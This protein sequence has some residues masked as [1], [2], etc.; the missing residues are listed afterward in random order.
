MLVPLQLIKFLLPLNILNMPYKILIVILLT[1]ITYIVKAQDK[2]GPKIKFGKITTEELSKNSYEIDTAAEAV[3]LYD[4]CNVQ[5]EG[6]QK[7]DFNVLYS[8]HMRI[9]ILNKNAFDLATVSIPLSKYSQMEEKVKKLEAITYNLEN[10]NIVESKLD[11]S[12]I[13]KDKVEKNFEI[14][15]FTLPNVKEGSVIEYVYTVISPYSRSLKKWAFQGRNPTLWSELNISIP[16]IYDFLT[17][18]YGTH[19]YS[20][21]KTTIGQSHYN[22]TIPSDHAAISNDH[23]NLRLNTY[24][25]NWAMQNLPAIKLEN[26][27]TNIKN[28]IAAIEFQLSTVRYPDQTPIPVIKPWTTACEQ[29]LKHEDFGAELYQ[30]NNWLKDELAKMSLPE[31]PV[32]KAKKIFV[33]V[34]DNF[35]CNDNSSLFL[36]S[37]LKKIYQT[38]AGNVADIN[39]LLTAMLVNANIEARP[40]ILSTKEN[41]KAFETQ[42]IFSKFNYVIA[43]A[44]INDSNYLLDASVKKIGFN[45]LPEKC[46]NGSAR[47]VDIGNPYLIPLSSEKIK[48]NKLTTVNIIADSAT[49]ELSGQFTSQLGYYES[50]NVRSE[51]GDGTTE[52]FFEKI[53]KSYAT[54]IDITQKEI[55]HLKEYDETA[56]VSYEFKF[57]PAN[58]GIIYLNPLFT[59]AYK[60]N[61]FKSAQRHYPVEMPYPVNEVFLFT[62]QIPEGYT[63]EEIP[64]S[65]RIKLNEDDEGMFEYII[66]KKEQLI[67]MRSTIRLKKATFMPE[68]YDTLRAF[69][70]QIVKKHAE[71][72]VIKPAK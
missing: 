47:S 51:I 56:I 34:R 57:P 64:K 41:G 3:V 37:S 27:T 5:Y 31:D 4:Y 21:N 42:A 40:A 71:Q 23:M 20:I 59:E 1:T 69:Y 72:I 39:L 32:E 10:G 9:K 11:K 6:D 44:I 7:A 28:H 33:Y 8:Y 68:E 65:V 53:K 55:E 2:E 61:P 43:Q 19:P 24:E 50:L 17:I 22:I 16:S 25:A 62:L 52:K 63:V 49:H 66:Q 48:E 30:K 58:D 14:H 45:K 60:T 13:F 26:Y 36:S 35:I 46:Y 38:K 18:K 29:L 54:D 70:A 67:Q 15:K 12:A